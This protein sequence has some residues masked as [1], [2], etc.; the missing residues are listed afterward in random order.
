MYLNNNKYLG[1]L[2][3]VCRCLFNLIWKVIDLIINFNLVIISSGIMKCWL[4]WE[5]LVKLIFIKFIWNNDKYF[6]NKLNI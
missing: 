3:L 2:G 4:C 5:Y 1:Y 6:I